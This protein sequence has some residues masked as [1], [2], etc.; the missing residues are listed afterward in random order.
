MS[1][2]VILRDSIGN[3]TFDSTLATGGV[4]LGF[5][6]PVSGALEFAFPDFIGHT[7]AVVNANV[8]TP[9]LLVTVDNALGYLRFTFSSFCIGGT[10]ILFAI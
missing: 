8:V 9:A 4:C 1:Y 10:Y 5:F 6:T 3:V 2:G 7:G